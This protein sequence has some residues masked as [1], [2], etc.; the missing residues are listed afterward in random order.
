MRPDAP[1]PVLN[2]AVEPL[3]PRP[4][5]RVEPVSAPAPISVEPRE[6]EPPPQILLSGELVVEIDHASGRFVRTLRDGE[7][8]EVLR[9]WPNEGQLAFARGVR[10]YLAALK[11]VL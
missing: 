8:D 9:R 7:T 4:E 3:A 11:S 10:A 1:P 6:Q 2:V 5:K